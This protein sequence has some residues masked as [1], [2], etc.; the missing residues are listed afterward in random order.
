MDS[1]RLTTTIIPIITTKYD[2][3]SKKPNIWPLCYS[4]K[5]PFTSLIPGK[6]SKHDAM[7]VDAKDGQNGSWVFRVLQVSS[8]W[9]SDDNNHGIQDVNEQVYD[10]EKDDHEKVV[11]N[12][13]C[14]ACRVDDDD[15]EDD[16]SEF[17]KNS[18]SNLLWNV[19][20]GEMR[21]YAQMA[22]L[23]SLSYTIPNIKVIITFFLIYSS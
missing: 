20:L 23:G 4:I 6:C 15:V 16:K 5:H 10:Q 13:E 7:V 9:K 22:Y 18:F 3:S 17:D 14:E 8:L 19:S 12:Q 11:M 1:L 2:K 21:L